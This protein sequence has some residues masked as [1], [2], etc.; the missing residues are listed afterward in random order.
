MCDDKLPMG[1]LTSGAR[2]GLLRQ[3]HQRAAALHKKGDEEEASEIV[4]KAYGLLRITW[5]RSI[6]DVLLRSVIAR[7]SEDVATT[8]LKEVEVLDEDHATVHAA[9]KKCSKYAAHDGAAIAN[10]GLGPRVDMFGY[11]RRVQLQRA[12]AKQ[13]VA[14]AITEPEFLSL[15]RGPWAVRQGGVQFIVDQ[16]QVAQALD[17]PVPPGGRR[18]VA[19]D[20]G[21]P[22]CLPTLGHYMFDGEAAGASLVLG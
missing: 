14:L 20:V 12:V 21:T 5:E 6:E 8:R 19:R 3:E 7:F 18:V 17:K 11:D 16:A 2:V 4:A 10:V 22:I 15:F 1:A 13:V 9:M